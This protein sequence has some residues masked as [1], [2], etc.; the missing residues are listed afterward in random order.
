MRLF[1]SA[2]LHELAEPIARIQE[3]FADASGL[4]FTD[5]SQAHITLKFLGETESKKLAKLKEEL[6]KA[7]EETSLGPFTANIE[8]L[9]VFPSL[10]YISVVW[11]GVNDG[12]E[13]LTRLH[14]EIETRTT[15]MG[16]DPEDHEFT[17]HATIARMDH[18][19]G[20]ELVQ[21]VVENQDP[22]LGTVTVEEIRLKKSGL[23]PDGPEYSTV[24]RFEL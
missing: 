8:G 20:K 14:E 19:G 5:P 17:P 10:D 21:D 2:D 6:T 1:V 9:G 15:A 13:Q 11:V 24:E 12:T 16:F 7:V 22:S 18:A 4:R 3:K 23:T